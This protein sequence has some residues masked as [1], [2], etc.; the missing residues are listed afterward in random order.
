MGGL[1]KNYQYG[2]PQKNGIVSMVASRDTQSFKKG[3]H[4]VNK[5]F[6]TWRPS[7]TRGA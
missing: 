1:P 4:Q 3:G 5:V 7:E 6:L 2:S